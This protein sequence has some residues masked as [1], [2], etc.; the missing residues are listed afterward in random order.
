[1][2]LVAREGLRLVGVGLVV[3]IVGGTAVTRLMEFMLYGVSPLD[4][5]TW[6]ICTALMLAAATFAV[7]V[8]AR[9]AARVDPL[10]AIQAE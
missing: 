1:M 9:R 6:V 4:V 2:R 10:V 3:G 8:P 7:L 5:R